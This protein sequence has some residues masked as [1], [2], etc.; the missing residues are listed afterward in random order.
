MLHIVS[1]EAVAEKLRLWAGQ[2]RLIIWTDKDRD[3]Q[4]R[5]LV[6]RDSLWLWFHDGVPA[7]LLQFLRDESLTAGPHFLI[8]IPPA[9]EVDQMAALAAAKS[10]LPNP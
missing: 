9:M 5:R 1:D 3:R 8:T 4:L 10:P 2:P 7:E 6:A